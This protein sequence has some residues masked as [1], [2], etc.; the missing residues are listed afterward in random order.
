MAQT[1]TN[2]INVNESMIG[3]YKLALSSITT[4]DVIKSAEKHIKNFNYIV[5]KWHL[6]KYGIKDKKTIKVLSEINDTTK[7]HSIKTEYI[8]FALYTNMSSI[9]CTSGILKGVVQV[10][11]VMNQLVCKKVSEYLNCYYIKGDSC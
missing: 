2:T 1:Q 4:D 10:K 3:Y 5:A 7:L 8:M 11:K 6:Y 9:D